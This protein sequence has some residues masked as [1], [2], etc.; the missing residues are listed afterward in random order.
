[1]S[2]G[3]QYSIKPSTDA[4]IRIN[5]QDSRSLG[6]LFFVHSILYLFPKMV[7]LSIWMYFLYLSLSIISI[8]L[9]VC[10]VTIF[11]IL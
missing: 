2:T 11:F 3:R 8:L 5:E 7:N 1:M 6:L 9:F 4:E 10:Y